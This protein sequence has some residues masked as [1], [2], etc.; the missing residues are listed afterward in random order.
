MDIR[1]QSLLWLFSI[2]AV[3]IHYFGMLVQMLTFLIFIFSSSSFCL[4][5][6]GG[7]L[8]LSEI[9]LSS[10][11]LIEIYYYYYYFTYCPLVKLSASALAYFFSVFSSGRV[12]AWLFVAKNL[13]MLI[14][15]EIW[16]SSLFHFADLSDEAS[17]WND[18]VNHKHRNK[19]I[20]P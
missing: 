3:C 20:T 8:Y 19:K 13:H 10:S 2:Y 1:W 14:Y 15:Q 6:W 17:W 16:S 7:W 12:Y 4:G 9:L 11:T 18:Q 5:G